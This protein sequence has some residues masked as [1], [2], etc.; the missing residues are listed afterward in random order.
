M[1]WTVDSH[2]NLPIIPTCRPLQHN[3]QMT[4]HIYV[5]LIK[6][7]VPFY[8]YWATYS[9]E[10]LLKHFTRKWPLQAREQ[11]KKTQ[12][13][14]PQHKNSWK[15]IQAV[16]ILPKDQT[17]H[18]KAKRQCTVSARLGTFSCWLQRNLQA[19]TLI[20]IISPPCDGQLR[21]EMLH[22]HANLCLKRN[23]DQ[24]PK[25]WRGKKNPRWRDMRNDNTDFRSSVFKVPDPHSVQWKHLQNLAGLSERFWVICLGRRHTE[26]W[27]QSL[28]IC[29]LH[30]LVGIRST[31]LLKWPLQQ[32]ASPITCDAW[33]VPRDQRS[34]GLSQISQ[35]WLAHKL[36]PKINTSRCSKCHQICTEQRWFVLT[37]DWIFHAQLLMHYSEVVQI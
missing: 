13:I 31:C 21:I 26:T 37:R 10:G 25:P 19:F 28:H 6:W 20:V 27:G 11:R 17:C 24:I 16:E 32:T 15:M 30:I 14:R 22:I 7:P 5:S 1:L 12:R 9:N 2:N 35:K 8:D 23:S 4:H 34:T 29:T 18:W 33:C 36:Y 3:W